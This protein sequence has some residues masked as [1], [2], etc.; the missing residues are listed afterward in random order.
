MKYNPLIKKGFESLGA[1]GGLGIGQVLFIRN[2]STASTNSNLYWNNTL[3]RLGIGTTNPQYN[4]DITSSGNPGFNLT[5]TGTG[6][7]AFTIYSTNNAA[8]IG[9]GALTIFDNTTL[10]HLF[11][12]YGTATNMIADEVNINRLTDGSFRLNFAS[13]GTSSRSYGFI[14]TNGSAS[15]GGGKFSLFDIT[16]NQH[17]MILDSIGNFGIGISS[18]SS[19]LDVNGDV[20]IPT[21]NFVYY[22]DPTTNG[23]VR[24]GI[25]GTNFVIQTR[26]ASVWTTKQ[27]TSLL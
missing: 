17:R 24:T 5:S 6:G 27:T 19:K 13:L 15:I 14:V 26:V 22:G 12:L 7:K 9:G 21:T 2:N 8:S 23:S 1:A 10:K 4:L 18:P 16:G 20:E 11:T 25:V 3:N